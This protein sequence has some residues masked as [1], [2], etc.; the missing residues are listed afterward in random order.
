MPTNTKIISMGQYLQMSSGYRDFIYSKYTIQGHIDS[1]RFDYNLNILEKFL[2]VRKKDVFAPTDR[3]I[4]EYVDTDFYIDEFPYGLTLH[5]IITAFK[6]IDIPLYTLLLYTNHFGISE[7]VNKLV[8]DPH[9]Q[10]TIIETFTHDMSN[11]YHDVD[12]GA[13]N[14]EMP[15]LSMM[16]ASRNHRHALYQFLKANNL[17]TQ[18]AVVKK[19]NNA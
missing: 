9:N 10:P 12:S 19:D 17:L 14:I 7:E 18:V 4:I 6:I 5:N 3:I 15:A 13:D 1:K 2:L 16:G 8:Q 11:N